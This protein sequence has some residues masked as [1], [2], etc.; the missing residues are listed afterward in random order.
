[1]SLRLRNERTRTIHVGRAGAPR[2]IRGNIVD[3]LTSSLAMALLFFYPTRLDDDAL[4]AGLGRALARYPLFAGRLRADGRGVSFECN[5]AGVP[6]TTADSDATLADAMA[7]VTGVR[8]QWLVD[9]MSMFKARAG[10][11]PVFTVRVT[12]LR[13]GATVLGVCWHHSLGDMRTFMGLALAWSAAVDGGET[14]EPLLIEDR[15]EYLARRIPENHAA[16]SPVRLLGWRELARFGL[17]MARPGSR[18][19]VQVYF[20][21]QEIRRMRGDLSERAGARLSVN[22]VVC[23]HVMAHL[24]ALQGGRASRV[25]SITVDMRRRLGLDPSL[26]GN[27]VNSVNL[28]CSRDDGPARIAAKVRHAID[29]YESEHNDYHAL[30][31]FVEALRSPLDLYRCVPLGID[32][33]RETVQMISWTKFG[34]YDVKFGGAAP[35]Y[36]TP[37]AVMPVPWLSSL[38]E[39]FEGHGILFSMGLPNAVADAFT[40]AESR[41]RLHAY[42]PDGDEMPAL[43]LAL[44]ELI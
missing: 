36:F 24:I 16:P 9:V 27:L 32:P 17:L 41:A 13:D 25:L 8:E 5:D 12:H 3:A 2:V 42:R 23:A 37:A 39:G 18:R 21:D 7:S 30:L 43:A 4:A 40:T 20:G 15:A 28:P 10:R 26:V 19:A 14:P 6:M 22:D 29:H 38:V 34:I 33:L 44:P 11:A 1:M 31:R 35:A